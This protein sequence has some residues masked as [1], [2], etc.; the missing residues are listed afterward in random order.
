[1]QNPCEWVGNSKD[2]LSSMPD[3]VKEEIGF[4]IWIA[5]SGGKHPSAKPLKGFGGA[6]VLEVVSNH[7]GNTY[8]GIYTV[9]FQEALYVLHVFQKKSRRG[10]ATPKHELDLIKSRLKAAEDHHR[11]HYAR[12][13]G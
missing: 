12:K 11:A 10:A 2:E 3:L 7:H 9:R 6:G 8:R 5:Q 13:T 1:M 4:A